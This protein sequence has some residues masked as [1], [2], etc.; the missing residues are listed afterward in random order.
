MRRFICLFIAVLMVVWGQPAAAESRET[1]GGLRISASAAILMEAT[2][3]RVLFEHNADQEMLIASTTKIMTALVAIELG[4]LADVVTIPEE[5]Q[6]I[7]GSSIYLRAG[8][9]LLL[10]DLLYGLMLQSGN[11]AAMAIACHVAGDVEHFVALMNR[12]AWE[13]GMEDTSFA[14]PHGLNQENHYST[15]RDLAR[16]GAAALRNTSL[17]EIA[18]TRQYVA[19]PVAEGGQTRII[20]N[21]NRLL[22]QDPRAIGLKIG[23]TIRAGRCLVAAATLNGIELVAVVL[24]APNWYSDCTA[25]FDFGF[26]GLTLEELIPGGKVMATVPVVGGKPGRIPIALKKPVCFPLW[27]GESVSFQ[28][29]LFIHEPIT[30]PIQP[31][32]VLGKAIIT[33]D[34]RW[35][36]E[37]ELVA[38]EGASALR[39]TLWQRL[40]NWVRRWGND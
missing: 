26:Q 7:E 10:K 38:M 11:D 9:Q 18:T 4:D 6:G 19:R 27:P 15:A 3:G 5:A 8:E 12:K 16:L 39:P 36:L 40:I 25:L 22:S 20:N 23:Y 17:R 30:A 34:H 31:G 33:V 21:K 13:L 29:E 35:Q 24:D 14:N 1:G 32:Q 28:A 37:G 2:S